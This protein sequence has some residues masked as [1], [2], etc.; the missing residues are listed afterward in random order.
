[1]K[2]AA[3]AC[4]V[5]VAT[6]AFASAPTA[7]DVSANVIEGGEINI[8]LAGSDA[9]TSLYNLEHIITQNPTNGSVEYYYPSYYPQYS[10]YVTYKS[11]GEPGT[12]VFK[13]KVKD[14]E[15]LESGE[16]TV[17]VTVEANTAPTAKN[18]SVSMVEGSVD[19]YIYMEGADAH[20]SRYQLEYHIVENP[21][22]G[23]LSD[24]SSPTYYIKKYTPDSGFVGTDTFKY[25]VRDPQGLESGTATV[26]ITITANVPPVANDQRFVAFAN[27]T[28]EYIYL[29]YADPDTQTKAFEI[30]TQPAHGRLTYTNTVYGQ[31]KYAPDPG[32]EG[33][34][35]FTWWVNDGITNSNVG[36]VEVLVRQAGN[37][38]GMT[39]AIVVQGSLY[40]EISNRVHRLESDLGNEGWTPAVKVWGS[41]GVQDLWNYLRSIYTSGSNWMSG[42]ILI[43]YNLPKPKEADICYWDLTTFNQNT[44]QTPDDIWVSRFASADVKQ[45]RNALD[46]NHYYRTDQSRLTRETWRCLNSGYTHNQSYLAAFLKVWDGT[47]DMPNGSISTPMREGGEVIYRS[48]HGSPST[49]TGPHQGRFCFI[50]GCQAG[51]I[52]G[53]VAKYQYTGFGANLTSCA[54]EHDTYFGYFSIDRT[55]HNYAWFPEQLNTGE[56]WGSCII[57]TPTY[58]NFRHTGFMYYGGLS[59]QAKMASTNLQPVVSSLSVSTTKPITGQPVTFTV[60]FTDSDA[61]ASDSPHV[62]F[63]YQVH[64]YMNT[65][66]WTKTPNYSLSD[67]NKLTHTFNT[68]GTYKV[69]AMVMDEWRAIT[70]VEKTVTVNTPPIASNDTATNI[71]WAGTDTFVYRVK[72]PGGLTDTAIVTV[73]VTADDSPPQVVSISS[74]GDPTLVTV[75][76]DEKVT[77][78]SGA[79]GAENTGNYSID[80][81]SKLYID[82]S[83]GSGQVALVVDNDG[84]PDTWETGNTLDP[85]D[86]ADRD[87]DNDGDGCSNYGEYIAGTSPAVRVGASDHLVCKATL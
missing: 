4:I 27:S 71:S 39:V 58:A 61:A 74:A 40:P 32:Y 78:G 52:N 86:P 14:E 18:V 54:S 21:T 17:T 12:D 47:N 80:N 36:T 51:K 1:M 25:K 50:S 55:L 76:F 66:G 57:Q 77:V 34:D 84:M 83:T 56:N 53:S 19:Q 31:F 46:A 41:G 44:L 69:R 22:H 60:N 33:T 3:L 70:W 7:G 13:Y 37:P 11:S 24:Y 6:P 20:T 45:L 15:G 23:A 30:L 63:E 85:L 10:Y 73:N 75:A 48:D 29:S 16:A 67:T 8:T 43:G 5:V 62:G 35:S 9:E 38:A 59:L 49:G 28:S 81:G 82:P 68:R 65:Y 79:D 42:A 2:W 72:D 87:L 26:A 64:W